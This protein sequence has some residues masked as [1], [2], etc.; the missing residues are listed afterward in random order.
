[1]ATISEKGQPSVN[2]SRFL[3]GIDFP[4]QKQDLLQ[5]ARKNQ[6]DSTVIDLIQQLEDREYDNMAEVMQAFGSQQFGAK[7]Q[8]Q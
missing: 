3:K 6:A 5:L 8:V 4:A 1:M 7:K 2:V